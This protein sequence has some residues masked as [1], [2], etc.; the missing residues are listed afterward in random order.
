MA[1]HG[2]CEKISSD[3]GSQFT[4][5]IF[6]SYVKSRDIK[7]HL[8]TEYYPQANGLVERFNKT[9]LKAMRTA[10]AEQKNWKKEIY[11]FLQIYRA[12]PHT[13]TDVSP[14]ELLMG[15]KIRTKLD[16]GSAN[17]STH[18]ETLAKARKKDAEYKLKQQEYTNQKRHASVSTINPGD[19]VLVK[20]IRK[21]N[22]LSPKFNPE[23]F[24]V[25]SKSG[26]QLTLR[27]KQGKT[28]RRNV[29]HVK[30]YH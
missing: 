11:N 18:A 22:K 6:N 3:R 10:H 12:T 9:L 23:P 15:R 16:I 27:D 17:Q 24:T 19:L 13:A 14:A 20:N 5:G 28:I 21:H 1:T 30:L 25:L 8:V 29:T 4:S 2:N 7:H 26:N